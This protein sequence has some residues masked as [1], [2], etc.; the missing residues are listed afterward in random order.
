VVSGMYDL[1]ALGIS[2]GCFAF[3]FGLLYLLSRV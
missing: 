3:A 2:V 1:V